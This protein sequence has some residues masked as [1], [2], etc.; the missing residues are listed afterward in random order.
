M[1]LP[2][3]ATAARPFPIALVL[4][5]GVV[6][7]EGRPMVA[8]V[9]QESCCCHSVAAR[10]RRSRSISMK[11]LAALDSLAAPSGL[12]RLHRAGTAA[13]A[14]DWPAWEAESSRGRSRVACP[15]HPSTRPSSESCGTR[16]QIPHGWIRR[17]P[18]GR[19]R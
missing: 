9:L 16:R 19:L 18:T 15:P 13:A 11:S 12:C 7:E 14:A 5:L 1:L 10:R 2:C 3:V 6:E 17:H 4:V 8:V